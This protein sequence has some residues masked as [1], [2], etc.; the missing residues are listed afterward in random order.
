GVQGV[1]IEISTDPGGT[2]DTGNKDNIIL[3]YPQVF[4]CPDH[5]AHYCTVTAAWTPDVRKES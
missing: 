3:L 2:S 1:K 5:A 4:Y